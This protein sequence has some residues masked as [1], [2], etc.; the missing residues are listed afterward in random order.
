MGHNST[1]KHVWLD[2]ESE[3]SEKGKAGLNDGQAEL[4]QISRPIFSAISIE[5]APEVLNQPAEIMK[6]RA[7]ARRCQMQRLFW[8]LLLSSEE[9]DCVL[10]VWIVYS[11]QLLEER[12][13]PSTVSESETHNPRRRRGPRPIDAQQ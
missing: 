13:M 5:S 11:T 4:E 12:T 8:D 10:C 7:L 6:A 2:Y 1:A 3:A 9:V